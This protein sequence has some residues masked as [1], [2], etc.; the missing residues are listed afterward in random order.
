MSYSAQLMPTVQGFP[1]GPVGACFGYTLVIHC[2][3]SAW[4]SPG[5]GLCQMPQADGRHGP[6][7]C[8]FDVISVRCPLFLDTWGPRDYSREPPKGPLA[9]SFT[10]DYRN[11]PVHDGPGKHR[12]CHEENLS[13]AQSEAKEDP[14]IPSPHEHGGWPKGA[15]PS[16]C[17]RKKAP[18]GLVVLLN[19]RKA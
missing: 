8:H 19:S 14:W 1:S 4:K 6:N 18:H 16:P 9:L 5:L 13:T 10:G 17:P 2:N 15:C 12:G 7:R 3:T 11:T